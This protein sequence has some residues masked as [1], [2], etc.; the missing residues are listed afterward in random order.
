MKNSV[1]ILKIINYTLKER[2]PPA[3][4]IEKVKLKDK[5]NK[6]NNYRSFK[7]EA[8]PYSLSWEQE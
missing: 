1:S 3:F 8:I 6:E 4:R 2:I 5:Q 7:E